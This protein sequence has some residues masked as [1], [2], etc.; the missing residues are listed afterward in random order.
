MLLY[1]R[2]YCSLSTL[3]RFWYLNVA[4]LHSIYKKLCNEVNLKVYMFENV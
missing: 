1:W 3:V 2:G 4:L